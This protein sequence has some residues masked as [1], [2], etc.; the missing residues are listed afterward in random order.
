MSAVRRNLF[1][2]FASTVLR[3]ASTSAVVRV[4][5]FLVSVQS[6]LVVH[7]RRKYLWSAVIE[8]MRPTLSSSAAAA[9]EAD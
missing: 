6:I 2:A 3:A 9:A 8:S 5:S 7:G 4:P 1:V